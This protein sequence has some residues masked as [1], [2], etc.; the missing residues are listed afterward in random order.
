MLHSSGVLQINYLQDKY[1]NKLLYTYDRYDRPKNLYLIPR[2][3]NDRIEL[4]EFI[5]NENTGNLVVI[6][7]SVAQRAVVFRY[8]NYHDDDISAIGYRYL[9]QIDYA[10]STPH[11]DSNS[12]YLFAL[13]SNRR[14]YIT[15]Y[16]S[17]EY[18]VHKKSP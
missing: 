12:W 17:A 9:R 14:E 10:V 18:T 7:D 1:G 4:L 11:A 2:G 6:Y 15:V 3:R 8:S 5:Y 16:D 13:D